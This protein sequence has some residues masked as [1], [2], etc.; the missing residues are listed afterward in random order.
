MSQVLSQEEVDALLNGLSDGEIKTTQNVIEEPSGVQS[1][2]L[3]SQDK[4]TRGRMPTLEMITEK[5]A[6]SF[7]TTLWMLLKKNIDIN[8]LSVGMAK[9][10]DFMKKIPI[11]TSLN[12]FKMTPLRGNSLLILESDIIFRLIDIVFG[13]SGQSVF[14]IEGREFTNIENNIIKKIVLNAL[15]DFESVWQTT[16]DLKIEYMRSETNP[17]FAQI[18]LSTDVMVFI[19]LELDIDYAT[20]AMTFCIPYATIEPI[21]KK[22]QA[23]YQAEKLDVDQKWTNRII[24]GIKDST[25]NLKVN[26]GQ[27]QLK[28]REIVNLKKGD[29]IPLDQYCNESLSVY[30]ENILKF[31]A[32]P[33]VY[34]SNHAILINELIGREKEDDS[35]GT[36]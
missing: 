13:G 12:V 33:G 29:V 23:E 18:A 22:L 4:I 9:Y 30:A 21:S 35:D 3:T 32:H 19:K 6:R 25:I 36:K 24:S 14:K 27:T 34:R 10:G 1:F 2:D 11:P 26:L 7:R 15:K 20:G 5:F 8:V 31:R 16:K 28:G 17:Q